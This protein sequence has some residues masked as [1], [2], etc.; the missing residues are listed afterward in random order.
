MQ[1]KIPAANRSLLSGLGTKILAGLNALAVTLGITQITPESFAA[2]LTAFTDALSAYNA[3]RSSRQSAYDLYHSNETDLTNWLKIVR[4]VLAGRFGDYWN[5]MW[6]Q[7]GFVQPS[8]AIPDRLQSRVALAQKLVKFFTDNPSYEVASMNVTA[9]KGTVLR[10]AFVS[11]QNALQ[12]ANV[13]QRTAGG[14]LRTAQAALVANMRALLSI[15]RATLS[16]SD[17]R[18]EA[19]GF[20]IPATKSTP[21]KP[22]GL[23]AT[24]VGS[25]VLL[26]C[27]PTALATRFRFRRKVAGVDTKYK[28]I[29]S[30]PTPMATV[31]N[32]AAGLTVS[33][34]VTAVNGD[35]QSVPSDPLVVVS[36]L[37]AETTAAPAAI[38]PQAAPLTGVVSDGNGNGNANGDANGSYSLNRI[39]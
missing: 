34:T 23:S 38:P 10:G 37:A 35:S 21:A 16:K 18:W 33:Y 1:N 28:L 17:P 15:L 5:T 36:S 20:N 9:A 29:A 39:T 25:Q 2:L 12:T 19:F 24:E 27:D 4:N 7:A 11:A 32:V 3:A 6:A 26:Q 14:A 22:T 30:S 13:T 8:T 31:D